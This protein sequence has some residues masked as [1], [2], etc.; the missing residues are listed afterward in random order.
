[1]QIGSQRLKLLRIGSI[2]IEYAQVQAGKDG[3]N[4]PVINSPQRFNLLPVAHSCGHINKLYVISKCIEVCE[5][6]LTS[7]K[8]SFLIAIKF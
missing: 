8:R 2:R 1:M 4:L 6:S 3:E 7:V 5:H